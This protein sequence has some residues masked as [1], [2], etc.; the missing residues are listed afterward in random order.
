MR[1][2]GRRRPRGGQHR[3]RRHRPERLKTAESLGAT[4][5]TP[6]EAED[7]ISDLTDWRGADVVVDA[8]GHP[9]ALAAI[10]GYVRS[11]GTVSIPGVYLQESL[12]VPWGAFWLKGVNFTMGVTHFHNSMDEVI[13]LIRAGRVDPGRIISHRMPLSQAD[14]AYRLVAA[15][16][17]TKVILDPAS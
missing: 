1:R 8:A 13:A 17:A 15:R 14:E 12:D 4:A 16:E 11:G 10:A 9:A 3:G 5:V 2:D 7:A 6:D